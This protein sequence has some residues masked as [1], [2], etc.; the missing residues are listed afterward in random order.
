MA[1]TTA[2]AISKL[3]A[4]QAAVD[5]AAQTTTVT[6]QPWTPDLVANLSLGVLAFSGF[7]LVIAA[8]LMWRVRASP[9]YVLKVVGVVSIIGFSAVLLVAGYSNDQL[10]PIV[11]LFGAIA[12]YLLGKDANGEK[13]EP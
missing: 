2:E 3:D 4:L 8:I 10:T 5:T 11:G 13:N 6:R 1:N 9:Q 7:T 12:G